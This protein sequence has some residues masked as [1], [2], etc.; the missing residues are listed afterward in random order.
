MKEQIMQNIQKLHK[1][2]LIVACIH[3]IVTFFTD[4]FIFDYVMWDMSN[5]TQM[6]K[7]AMTYGAKAVF[8]LVLIGIYQ[9]G[10]FLF[11]KADKGLFVI[12]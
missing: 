4:H 12:P 8:L 10:Y 6:I 11:T 7:T 9:G 1:G 5:T 3:W 2:C